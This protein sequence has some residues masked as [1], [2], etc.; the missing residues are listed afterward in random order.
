MHTIT[1]TID[2]K[3]G[4]KIAVDGLKGAA[5]KDVTKTLENALGTVRDDTKTSEYYQ[6]SQV[7]Q[8][9]KLGH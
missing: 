6:Q 8:Q 4:I 5:C 2:N 9:Q 3:G 1:L 7:G